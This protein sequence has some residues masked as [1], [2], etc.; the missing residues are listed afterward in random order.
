MTHVA[1]GSVPGREPEVGPDLGPELGPADRPA[2]GPAPEVA[3]GQVGSAALLAAGVIAAK[4]RGD[5]EGASALLA[6]FPDAAAQTLGF[7][8]VGDL[9]V[10]LLSQATGQSVE[11]CTRRLSLALARGMPQ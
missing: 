8:V 10:V 3:S 4:R 11:D 5:D 9:A 6:A 7:Y 1:E 2:D